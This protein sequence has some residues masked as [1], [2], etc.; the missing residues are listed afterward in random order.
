VS[1]HAFQLQKIPKKCLAM[2][3]VIVTNGVILRSLGG[4]MR[5]FM[6]FPPRTLRFRL[7]LI[8]AS[9]LLLLAAFGSNTN[10]QSLIAYYNFEGT[11]TPGFPVNLESHPPAFFSS[12]NTLIVSFNPNSLVEVSPGLPQNLYPG[13]P[14][15]NLTALGF[16]RS[17]MNSPA[18]LDIPL[19]SAQGFFQDMTLSFAIN[20]QGNGFT[21]TN[22]Y[23]ST[24]AGGTF[25]LFHTQELPESGTI[26][27][28][29]AVPTAANNAP[30]LMLRIELTGGQSNG[31]NLQNVIDNIRVEGTIVPEPATVAGG[32]LGVLGL[33]W[34]QRRRLIRSVRLRRT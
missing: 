6:R 22:L 19:F 8:L 26:I 16:N 11:D 14:A 25:T 27:V 31:Q 10:A 15:P 2:L 20:A 4:Y 30:A 1:E 9:A 29:A 33:C 5:K 12:G 32:F 23:F 13:D 34:H 7:L 28:S 18:H 24:D 17:G 3:A 21:T